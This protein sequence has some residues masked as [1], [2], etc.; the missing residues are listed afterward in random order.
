MVRKVRRPLWR[1][2]GLRAGDGRG[3]GSR[4]VKF[5]RLKKPTPRIFRL[6]CVLLFG[7]E[8]KFEKKGLFSFATVF[9]FFLFSS[10]PFAFSIYFDGMHENVMALGNVQYCSAP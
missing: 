8:T 9:S 10:F 2:P 7:K 1:S 3:W 5:E 4:A 6:R